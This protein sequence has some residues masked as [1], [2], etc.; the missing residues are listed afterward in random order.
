MVILSDEESAGCPTGVQWSSDSQS[1][2][3]QA[4][5]FENST[6]SIG[7][8]VYVQ[9]TEANLQPHIVCIE[10]LWKDESGEQKCVTSSSLRLDL[11]W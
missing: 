1:D 7:D 5:S 6:Y 8:F 4:C 10:K 11:S 2:Y 9:P 3:S